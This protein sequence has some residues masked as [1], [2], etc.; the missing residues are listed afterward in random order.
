M[1]F[2]LEKVSH[3]GLDRLHE[4]VSGF[5]QSMF[6]GRCF[7]ECFCTDLSSIRDES[8]KLAVLMLDVY[9]AYSV[10][11]HQSRRAF[12]QR[13]DQEQ[14][15]QPLFDDF[16]TEIAN[17]GAEHS[18]L[19]S[20]SKS[21]SNYLYAG[22]LKLQCFQDLSQYS[23]NEHFEDFRNLNGNICC[24]CGLE[25]YAELRE[26]SGDLENLDESQWRGDYDHLLCK[27]KYP[28]LSVDF[29]NLVPTC[30][31]CNRDAKKA[32]DILCLDCDRTV[33]FHPYKEEQGANCSLSVDVEDGLCME[34]KVEFSSDN[35]IQRAKSETW[36]FT[37][38]IRSR[39]QKRIR[40]HSQSYY[41]ASIRGTPSLARAR[42]AL[43][44]GA[45]DALEDLRYR[46]E[47]FMEAEC[48]RVLSELDD[49][50]LRPIFLSINDHFEGRD[51]ING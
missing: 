4:M 19:W 39:Y 41:A 5:Y 24:F 47:S 17:L 13:F 23:L 8:P 9:Q 49:E 7:D 33:A 34:W 37:Y 28:F 31:T 14:N 42:D 20:K 25:E 6:Q 10:L 22:V 16:A 18:D 40:D 30:R 48:L 45:Q 32:I 21:L 3:T 43:A 11:G 36:L 50:A 26:L 27:S 15:I 35:D 1:L 51:I 44:K 2:N 12:Q 46:R 29:D 38:D